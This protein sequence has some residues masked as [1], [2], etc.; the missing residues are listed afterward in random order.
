[1]A[2]TP[3]RTAQPPTYDSLYIDITRVRE[4]GLAKL[5]VLDIPA[6]K[7]AARALD[8][9]DERR[10]VGPPVI[11]QLLRDGLAELDGQIA[12]IV[13]VVFGLEPG[14]RNQT[15]A[16]NRRDMADRLG[17]NF[18][19]F[20]LNKEK[21]AREQLTEVILRLIEEHHTRLAFLEMSR[22]V[23]VQTRLAVKWVERFEAYYRLWTPISGIGNELTAYR[24]TLLEEDRPYDETPEPDDPDDDPHT[25]DRQA[26]GYATSAWQFYASFLLKLRDFERCYG[27]HWFFSDGD[28]EQAVAD[29]VYRIVHASPYNTRDDSSLRLAQLVAEENNV[30]LRDLAE[31]TDSEQHAFLIGATGESL[32]M[33]AHWEWQDWVD[34]CNCTWQLGKALDWSFFATSREYPSIQATCGM[35]KMI[36]ACNDYMRLVDD[37]WARIADWYGVDHK[38]RPGVPGEWLYRD[39]E[40][41]GH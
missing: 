20:R 1:M 22:R 24:S 15:P 31:R 32:V 25:Q 39:P 19:Y 3:S 4:R 34:D 16:Q 21:P 23:P 41:D 18:D 40:S 11:E 35:H 14:Y 37:E 17:Y 5:R 9:V 12:D 30:R 6:L 10:E 33:A 29:A 13:S 26:M 8:R 2:K 7:Q 38:A 36:S 28:T 27:G